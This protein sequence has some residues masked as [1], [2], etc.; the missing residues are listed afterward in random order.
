VQ[1][2]L[3]REQIKPAPAT[4]APAT[5]GRGAAEAVR[6]I[7]SRYMQPL[8]DSAI[9]PDQPLFDA[10]LDSLGALDLISQ[11]EQHFGT[12]VSQT[13]LYD[14][15]TI[16]GLASYFE[17]TGE[18][19]TRQPPAGA[20]AADENRAS[21]STPGAI[22]RSA[23]TPVSVLLQSAGI[24]LRPLVLALSILPVLILFDLCAQRLSRLEL[25][26]TGPAGSLCCWPIRWRLLSS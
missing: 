5:V 2:H 19:A 24:F 16:N 15:P 26:L 23:T 14:H 13:L 12:T 8:T 21:E 22:R 17:A 6:Q 4:P 11:L 25:F 1:K 20:A 10:G 3:I 18:A 9:A 7:V